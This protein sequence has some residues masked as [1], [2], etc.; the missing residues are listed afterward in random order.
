MSTAESIP[1]LFEHD[2]KA[3]V[4]PTKTPL[5]VTRAYLDDLEKFLSYFS[6]ESPDLR[7]NSIRKELLTVADILE[8]LHFRPETQGVGHG[9]GEWLIPIPEGIPVDPEDLS[10]GVYF[11]PEDP[12]INPSTPPKQG[13]QLNPKKGD[14]YV[15]FKPPYPVGV[16][17]NLSVGISVLRLLQEK[18]LLYTAPVGNASWDFWVDVSEENLPILEEILGHLV[19]GLTFRFRFPV[20]RR[21]KKKQHVPHPWYPDSSDLITG[22]ILSQILGLSR[23]KPRCGRDWNPSTGEFKWGEDDMIDPNVLA[24]LH[25]REFQLKLNRYPGMHFE[26]EE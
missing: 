13:N 19:Q 26:G 8:Y 21:G 4:T 18:G 22:Y 20:L 14:Q 16:R 6:G 7:M 10:K 23:D 3:I 5:L 9:P 11:N 1:R 15:M 12:R 24:K 17:G 2:Q 25:K